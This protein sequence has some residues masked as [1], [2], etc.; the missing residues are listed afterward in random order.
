MVCTTLCIHAMIGLIISLLANRT[1]TPTMTCQTALLFLLVASA[2]TEVSSFAPQSHRSRLAH[3]TIPPAYTQLAAMERLHDTST[4]SYSIEHV[5]THRD[6]DFI[7]RRI[8][9]DEWT[10]LGSVIAE[11]MHETILDVGND[12][13]KQRSWTDRITLTD[14]IAEEVSSAVEVSS[15]LHCTSTNYNMVYM[16]AIS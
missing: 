2:S 11:T 12:A 10:A 13:L 8:A 3:P 9:R 14:R 1:H 16:C 4:N 6:I 5:Y 15:F 7:T